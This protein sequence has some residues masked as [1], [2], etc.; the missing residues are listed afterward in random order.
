MFIIDTQLPAELPENLS[1]MMGALEKTLG[2]VPPH[3]NLMAILNP[4]EAESNL[5]YI[6]KL[7][8]HETI[9]PDL[10]AFIRLHVAH[11]EGFKYCINFNT[12]LLKARGYGDDLLDHVKADISAVPFTEREKSLVEMGIEALY[13][14][15]E[16]GRDELKA[17][18]ALGWSDGEIF[19]VINHA[20]FL[21]KNGRIIGLYLE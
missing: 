5:N 17:L 2:E 1:K 10:F 18:H 20:A 11:R 12:A 6:F 7:M 8:Q 3:F 14:P 15:A 19:D 21:I 4:A 13:S 9:K 16:F